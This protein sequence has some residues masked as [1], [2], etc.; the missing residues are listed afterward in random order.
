M[1]AATVLAETLATQR[2]RRH[3]A[4]DARPRRARA[5]TPP[6][7]QGWSVVAALDTKLATVLERANKDSMNLYA[8]CPLQAARPRER[9]GSPARGRTAPPRWA[10]SSSASASPRTQ[11]K[12]DDGSRPLARERDQPRRDPESP[13][14]QFPAPAPRRVR[15]QPRRRRRG[16]DVREALQE[17][18]EGPRLRQ[19]RLHRR[20]QRAERLREDRRT[21]S[22]SRSRS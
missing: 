13:R 14:P 5:A 7:R 10:T 22:G 2:R 9:A 3:R 19:E 15:H 4:D 1:F 11:F 20:R 6:I 8:E 17:Q 16:R 21:A 12:L 18:P